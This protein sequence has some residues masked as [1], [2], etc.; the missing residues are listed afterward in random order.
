MDVKVFRTVSELRRWFERNHDQVDE[1]WIGYYKKASGKRSVTY[2]EAL[3][4]ALCFGWIDGLQ[5]TVDDE[6]YCNRFTPRRRRS[7]WSEVNVRKM[8]G[9]IRSGKVTPAGLKAFE[10]HDEPGRAQSTQTR[11]PEMTGSYLERL[12]VNERAWCYFQRQPPAYRKKA[13][14]WVMSAKKEETRDR[15]LAT[16]LED[17]EKEQ[18]IAPMRIAR[19]GR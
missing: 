4:E 5:R 15:R 12:M 1:L 13:A 9:L 10:G 16:L 3:D 11:A 6:V 2:L 19:S 8:E 17:C 18:W 7:K 14:F